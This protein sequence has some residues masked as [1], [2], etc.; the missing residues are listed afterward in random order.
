MRHQHRSLVQTLLQRGKLSL[1]ADPRERIERTKRLIQ[2]QQ[3]L[4]RRQGAG[5][6]DALPLST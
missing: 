4:L 6:T 5:N 1:Q 2:Q 3:R